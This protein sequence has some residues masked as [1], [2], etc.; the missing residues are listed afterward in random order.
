MESLEYDILALVRD[1]QCQKLACRE[2][3][4]VRIRSPLFLGK[5]DSLRISGRALGRADSLSTDLVGEEEFGA[6]W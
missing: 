5:R 2:E 4:S 1:R 6:F 3:E